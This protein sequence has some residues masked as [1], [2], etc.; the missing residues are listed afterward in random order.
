MMRWVGELARGVWRSGGGGSGL[1]ALEDG[2]VGEGA[3]D[4]EG[5]GEEQEEEKEPAEAGD[6]RLGGAAT[7]A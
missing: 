4:S 5:A 6:D 3:V 1:G 7:A 2:P